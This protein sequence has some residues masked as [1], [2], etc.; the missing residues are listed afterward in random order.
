MTLVAGI[1]FFVYEL[2]ENGFGAE[3]AT[4]LSSF[5]IGLS[6]MSGAFRMIC[7]TCYFSN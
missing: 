5:A 4:V 3:T 1:G 7:F 2:T 6:G